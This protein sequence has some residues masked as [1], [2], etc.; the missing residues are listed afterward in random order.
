MAAMVPIARDVAG[1]LER[2]HGAETPMSRMIHAL[3]DQAKDI[4]HAVSGDDVSG[5]WLKHA[6]ETPGYVLGAPTGQLATSA[7]YLWDV[8]NGKEDP[9]DVKE[10]AHGLMYGKSK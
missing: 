7:Q 2:G 9:Q 10:W 3:G 5:K 4:G 8:S 6:I 1:Y